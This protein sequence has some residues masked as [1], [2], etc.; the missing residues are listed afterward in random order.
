MRPIGHTRDCNRSPMAVQQMRWLTGVLATRP[1]PPV[2][3]PP[4]GKPPAAASGFGQAGA[5]P[6]GG[7][8]G[9]RAPPTPGGGGGRGGGASRGG[10]GG[11]GRPPRDPGGGSPG[12]EPPPPRGP[13]LEPHTADAAGQPPEHGRDVARGP[14]PARRKQPGSLGQGKEA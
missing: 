9:A 4:V 2:R 10:G 5:P 7:P 8:G 1:S 3:R 6:P 11:G 12:G 14:V 13:G